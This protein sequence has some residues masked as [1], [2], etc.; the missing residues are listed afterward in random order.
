MWNL[1]AEETREGA[2]YRLLLDKLEVQR[3]RLGGRVFDVLGEAFRGRPLRELLLEAIRYG[4]DPAR[5][6][7]LR[8]VIDERVGDGIAVLVGRPALAPDVL[9]ME[10][11]TAIRA[12]LEE[13]QARRLQPHYV[14]AFFLEA[15]RLLGGRAVER[16]PGRYEITRVPLDV[17]SR[18][19][20][21]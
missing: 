5:A 10:Q 14:R 18:D 21:I 13:A 3:Q 6:A 9:G 8:G 19:R 20:L 12:D 17:R 1:V 16:E 4:D 7:E 11:V 15:F 2:V